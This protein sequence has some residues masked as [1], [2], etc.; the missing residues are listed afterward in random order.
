MWVLY[1]NGQDAMEALQ[2]NQKEVWNLMCVGLSVL[3]FSISPF[4][5]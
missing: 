2:M 5:S 4:Q 3:W 1:K